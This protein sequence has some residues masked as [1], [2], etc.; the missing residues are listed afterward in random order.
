MATDIHTKSK[1]FAAVQTVLLGLFAVIFFLD[2]TARLTSS[3]RAAAGGAV[4]CLAGLLLMLAAFL[5]IRAVVQIAPE[6]KPGGHLVTRGVYRTLR[7]PIYTGMLLLLAGLFL[8]KPTFPVAVTAAVIGA[9]LVMK[10]RF[11]EQ[12]LLN[13]Y[14]D[15]ADYKTRSW[16]I[17]P[18]LR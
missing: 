11:E 15:Y 4:L 17:I 3:R 1:R 5:S 14:P 8:R 18:G 7:H 2:R 6:P 12:L 13:R 16:G 9:V 10:A